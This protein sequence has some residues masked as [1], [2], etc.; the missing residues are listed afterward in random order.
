MSTMPT[1]P[2]QRVLDRFFLHGTVDAVEDITPRM[3]RIR[4]IGESLRGL[5]WVPGQHIRLRVGNLSGPQTW[6]R[7]FR[8]ALRTYSIWDYDD[9]GR[10]DVC[11]LDHAEPG[12]GARWS[13]KAH[14]GQRVAL[15]PPEGRLR[16]QD[17]APYHLFVGDETASVA[18]GAML[19]AL[20]A[21]AHVYTVLEAGTPADRLPLARP[22]NITWIY[23]D[24]APTTD[25]GVLLL[26]ALRSLQLPTVPGMAYIAWEARS[27]Q[28]ARR[29]FNHER[30]W[31]RKAV[32][33]KAFWAPGRRGLD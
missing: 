20:P 23:R 3:R 31:P 22:R 6:I 13:R 30:N 10:L 7:G 21:S 12:P 16:I 19:R 32:T 15:T 9:Y 14:I 5:T 27:C 4:I 26:H 1:P 29:H 33:V 11:I 25:S 8:D 24:N 18:F 2:T 17:A 28:V